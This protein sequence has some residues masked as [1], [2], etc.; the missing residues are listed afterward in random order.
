KPGDSLN[1]TVVTPD[2]EPREVTLTLGLQPEE[3]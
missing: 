3:R 2:E 1:L